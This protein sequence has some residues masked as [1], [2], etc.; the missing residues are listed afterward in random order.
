MENTPGIESARKAVNKAQKKQTAKKSQENEAELKAKISA[1]ELAKEN[2]RPHSD[3]VK[4]EVTVL[5]RAI[6][7]P[8]VSPG[9]TAAIVANFLRQHG[10]LDKNLVNKLSEFVTAKAVWFERSFSVRLRPGPPAN[11][12]N[13]DSPDYVGN[14][15]VGDNFRVSGVSSG[16]N[17]PMLYPGMEHQARMK[18]V[19]DRVKSGIRDKFGTYFTKRLEGKPERLVVTV[20][21][22]EAPWVL[23][24]AQRVVRDA[25]QSLDANMRAAAQP[26]EV[27]FIVSG[28][29]YRVWY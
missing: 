11:K 7:N 5:V 8:S 29:S 27:Y 12:A 23:G 26:I 25:V 13:A 18:D 20:D 28:R 21:I 1:L 4:L 24:E 10:V 16:V 19:I 9:E 17:A 2:A 6:V 22:S 15:I 3:K 14:G